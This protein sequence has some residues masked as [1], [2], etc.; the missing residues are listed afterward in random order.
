MDESPVK[1]SFVLVSILTGFRGYLSGKASTY[2]DYPR[3]CRQG[4]H[5]CICD[6]DGSQVVCLRVQV[7]FQQRLVLA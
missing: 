6:G 5:L 3:V 2:K 7:L 1:I 4:V